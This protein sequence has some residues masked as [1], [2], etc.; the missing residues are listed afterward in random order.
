M[1]DGVMALSRLGYEKTASE[2]YLMV[3]HNPRYSTGN[4]FIAYVVFLAHTTDQ[5]TLWNTLP[6]MLSR[7]PKYGPLWFFAL[8]LLQHDCFVQW[9]G[10]GVLFEYGEFERVGKTALNTLT[11]DI[12][13]KV[14]FM[15]VQFW[16][17][18][19][20]Q[21]YHMDYPKVGN[22]GNNIVLADINIFTIM[23]II[24]IILFT[25]RHT[26]D[27]KRSR[28]HIAIFTMQYK[29]ML[30]KPFSVAKRIFTG[31]SLPYL[32]VMPRLREIVFKPFR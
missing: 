18:L 9:D 7:F 22:E 29:K 28:E 12:V 16:S 8:D 20:L 26:P 4:F 1:M 19:L 5:Q 32:H 15:R 25:Y 10:Q 23:I 17:R 2:Y 11:S 14:Y 13:W 6:D 27:R 21:L 24:I 30:K 3:T 31:K